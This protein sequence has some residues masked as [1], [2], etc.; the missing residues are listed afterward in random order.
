MSRKINSSGLQLVKKFEGL[1][2]LCYDDSVGVATIVDYA[3]DSDLTYN[4]FVLC[5]GISA[6]GDMIM[7]APATRSGNAYKNSGNDNI[8]QQTSRNN[9]Y[10]IVA[11][12]YYEASQ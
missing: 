5:V 6:D 4:H 10:K 9:G 1:R 7:N 8:I 11:R 12:D 2:L 3:T